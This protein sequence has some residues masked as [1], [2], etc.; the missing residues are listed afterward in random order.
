MN[1]FIIN[2]ST[3]YALRLQW[4]KNYRM[5]IK[6]RLIIIIFM[7]FYP[8]IHPSSV[9]REPP[10]GHGHTIH[11]HAVTSIPAMLSDPLWKIRPVV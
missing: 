7:K 3:I 4:Y 2:V 1:L 11:H 6:L 8:L 9:N 5:R 10:K